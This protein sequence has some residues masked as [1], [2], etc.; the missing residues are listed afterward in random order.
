MITEMQEALSDLQVADF[1][2]LGIYMHLPGPE[3]TFGMEAGITLR[4]KKSERKLEARCVLDGADY[5][6][7]TGPNWD[8][9]LNAIVEGVIE[10]VKAVLK[11]YKRDEEFELYK[12]MLE[13]VKRQ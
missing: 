8:A 1:D 10:T 2:R 13:A 5:A 9:K 3:N 11:R 6:G 4:L 12:A 7:R